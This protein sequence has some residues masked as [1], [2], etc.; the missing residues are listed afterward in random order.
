MTILFCCVMF[1]GYAAVY[2]AMRRH[3][4]GLTPEERAIEDAQTDQDLSV[5]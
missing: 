1:A 3:E 4:A 2:L 5:W